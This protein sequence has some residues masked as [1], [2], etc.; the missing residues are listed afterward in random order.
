MVRIPCLTLTTYE[1]LLAGVFPGPGDLA[2][3]MTDGQVQ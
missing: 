1:V 3:M 2:L